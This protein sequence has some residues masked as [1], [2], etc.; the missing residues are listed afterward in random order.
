MEKKKCSRKGCPCGGS[1]ETTRYRKDANIWY[2]EI[3]TQEARRLRKEARLKR[4]AKPLSPFCNVVLDDGTICG[5]PTAERYREVDR[6][7]CH[8]NEA[9][10]TRI[11]QFSKWYEVNKEAKK[12]YSKD[13]HEANR[14]SILLRQKAYTLSHKEERKLTNDLSMAVMWFRNF[15]TMKRLDRNFNYYTFCDEQ[16]RDF[17]IRDFFKVGLYIKNEHALIMPK[18]L[19]N[20]KKIDLSIVELGLYIE[21]KSTEATYKAK[22]TQEQ[23]DEYRDLLNFEITNGYTK[24]HKATFI[25]FSPTGD[26]AEMSLREFYLFMKDRIISE[27]KRLGR[28]RFK[29][30]FPTVK[31]MALIKLCDKRAKQLLGVEKYSPKSSKYNNDDLKQGLIEK[32]LSGE[33]VNTKINMNLLR[34]KYGPQ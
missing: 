17:V 15:L 20:R 14:D 5:Q 19:R 10:E 9:K 18:S 23:V 26:N 29:K 1:T 25:S 16:S 7:L 34:E 6:C 28:D 33:I 32:L 12:Q 22:E 30:K 13:Y 11:E 31:Y 3:A 27:Y 2:C 24:N 4:L 21:T 8:V